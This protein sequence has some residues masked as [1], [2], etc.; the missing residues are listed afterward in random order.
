M[1]CHMMQLSSDSLMP[2]LIP[3]QAPY[4]DALISLT[5]SQ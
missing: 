2:D 5:I 4:I 3:D 1:V